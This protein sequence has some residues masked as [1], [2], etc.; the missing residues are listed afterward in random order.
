MA[1]ALEPGRVWPN[2]PSYYIGV[3]MEENKVVT[4]EWVCDETHICPFRSLVLPSVHALVIRYDKRM[5]ARGQ[6]HQPGKP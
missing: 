1:G 3:N 4:D 5:H 2:K 6:V